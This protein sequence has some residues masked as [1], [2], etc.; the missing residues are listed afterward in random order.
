MGVILDLGG[1]QTHPICSFMCADNYW[2]MSQS[3][4]HLEQILKDLIQKQE[5][6]IQK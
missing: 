2:V 1:H 3:R 5:D 6:G 4:T